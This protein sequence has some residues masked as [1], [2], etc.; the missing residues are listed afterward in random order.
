MTPH[1]S[2]TSRRTYSD[3]AVHRFAIGSFVRL[4]RNAVAAG[5]SE[6]RFSV[7][8]QL[9]AHEGSPQ[10]RIRSSTELH[11]RMVMQSDLEPVNG[12]NSQGAK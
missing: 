4:R 3:G 12:E 8:A 1:D 5:Q 7:T 10:Y 11:D 2:K 9:P 6:A